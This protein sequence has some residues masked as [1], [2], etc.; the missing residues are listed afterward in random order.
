MRVDNDEL[1][2]RWR[3]RVEDEMEKVGDG[4]ST[5]GQEKGTKIES[6]DLGL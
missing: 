2:E 5:H 1:V 3:E 6:G 4:S